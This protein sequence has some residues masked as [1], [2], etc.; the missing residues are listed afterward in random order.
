MRLARCAGLLAGLAALAIG[1]P[2]R[3]A[4]IAQTPFG[5]L[6]PV[7]VIHAGKTADW[8][9][10]TPGAVWVGSTGPF[11]V[12]R[13]DPTAN[14][15]AAKIVLPGEPCAGLAAG[16]GAL[17]V[18]LCGDRPALARV[19]LKSN[20]VTALFRVSGVQ[21]EG[22]VAVSPR[23]VWLVVDQQGSLV[24]IDPRNGKILRTAT[25]PAGAFNPRYRD[26]VVW[27]SRVEGAATIAVDARTGR[28]LGS[29]P[30][31]PNPRFLA[32]GAGA[33][34]TLNQGDGSLTR[35]DAG[36]RKAAWTTALG[37]P[38]HGGDIAFGAGVVW[39][40]MAGVPLTATDAVTG[41]VRRQWV[42][43]GGDSL[44]VGRDAIWLTDYHAGTIARIR[45]K[46]ALPR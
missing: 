27:V 2:S 12:N 18:P 46:D 26:G 9:A 43:P 35:I 31:G 45:L 21:A 38:G 5:D 30:T 19:D 14:R 17:W 42:G 33:V 39:T 36:S 16:F 34:W 29:T 10:I 32:T 41:R 1:A 7:A 11:A 25:L 23:G 24:G 40:T 4:P 15:L 3:A 13:I 8:V 6:R 37:T 28:V 20:R 44:A 22:G